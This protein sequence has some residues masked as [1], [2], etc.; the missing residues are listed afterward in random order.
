MGRSRTW[1]GSSVEIPAL[2]LIGR[3]SYRFSNLRLIASGCIVG[4]A[5]Y[6]AMVFVPGPVLSWDSRS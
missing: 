5:Y 6:A 3:L 4:I 2:L 1:G